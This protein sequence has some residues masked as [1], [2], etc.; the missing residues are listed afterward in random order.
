MLY[1]VFICHA[2]EDKDSFVRPLA[3]KLREN[4]VEVWY[5][6]FSLKV[7]DSLRRSIDKGLSKSRFGIVVLSKN[8]FKKEWPQRELDGLVQIETNKRTKNILPIWYGITHEEVLT[9]SP[10][11]ADKYA[12]PSDKGLDFIISELLKVIQP[13]G[14]T[15]IIA[16]DILLEYGHDPPVVT[17]DWW[18]DVVEFSGTNPF[19]GNMYES[20]GWGR[21]GFPLP[22]KGE[23]ASERGKRL[24]QAA[25]QMLWES[26]AENLRISQITHPDVVIDFIAST[27]GLSETCREYLP[28][29]AT[30]APQL[31]IKGL[32]GMFE[33]DFENWYQ[34]C[35][36]E[37]KS[38]CSSLKLRS[39]NL[40]K[41]DPTW[42]SCSFVQGEDIIGA[43]P[44]KFYETID[45]VIWFLSTQSSWMPREIH[46]FLLEGL[47]RWAVW[48]WLGT[49]SI[50]YNFGFEENTSTGSLQGAMLNYKFKKKKSG[51]FKLTKDCLRD[52]ETRFEYAIDLLGLEET[53][54]VLV[55]R[56]LEAGFIEAW[57]RKRKGARR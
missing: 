34:Y 16:R 29:L 45:Y 55:Q 6:E 37:K 15:L 21:W 30:Y 44:V 11:L 57:L 20:A 3:E 35:V 43:P 19:E 9:Y 49:P 14:S 38:L 36:T 39:P 17:D 8:F 12:L 2:S 24:A 54:D 32:G 56:F 51:P 27:P 52:I 22:P 47:R 4:H 25:M 50:N 18:L 31:V 53:V 41:Y 5:D 33:E 23:T 26:K 7:G 42:I 10:T 46:Q 40:D 1:D 13:E 48:P 28:Y